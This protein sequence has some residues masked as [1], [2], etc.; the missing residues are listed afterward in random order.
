MPPLMAPQVTL[1]AK[2]SL[3]NSF[4][5]KGNLPKDS[6]TAPVEALC[7][8]ICAGWAIW[9]SSATLVG[10]M[11]NGP[12]ASGGQ[13]VGPPLDP[14]IRANIPPTFKQFMDP[15]AGGLGEQFTKFCATIK[16]PGM[17]WY[18]AFAAF[19]GPVAPPMPNI[20]CPLLALVQGGQG[21]MNRIV[22]KQVMVS[23]LPK[24]RTS[25]AEHICDAVCAG[26]DSALTM[27]LT[28]TM[29][30]NVLGTG[31][32]PTFAPPYVPV[33][34]VVGGTGNQIPGGMT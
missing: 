18:P 15:V 2:S 9:Q 13:L 1:F 4:L 34:N 14:L 23:R 25:D 32:I 12:V 31:P 24:S 7:K 19:P 27:W 16:V 17:P 3:Q 20:P 6:V 5:A 11:I 21:F 33:G 30:T 28:T 22:L 26:I 10:V 29:V 8:A